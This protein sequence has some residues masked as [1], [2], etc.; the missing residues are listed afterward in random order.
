MAGMNAWQMAKKQLEIVA[1]FM[2]LE[3]W[4]YHKLSEC[5]RSLIVSVPVKMD[6]GDVM[7]FEGYRVQHNLDRGPAKGGV[8]LHPDVT[9]DEVKALAM[10][11][12][13]KCAV[14]NI[15][16]GGAKGGIACDPEKLSKGELERL[17]RRYT[18]EI[19]IIIG[20][21]KD[22]PA[23]DVNTDA[24]IMAWMMDTYSMNVGYSSPGVVTGKPISIGGSKGRNE[25][26]GKGLLIVVENLLK[27]IGKNL[28]DVEIV[29]QGFGNV[30]GNFCRL[31]YEKGAKIIAVSDVSGGIFNKKGLDINKLAK[32]VSENKS[33]KG[34][35][36]GDEISN[37]ELLE[38]SCD[39]LV[40]AALENQI[41]KE[42]A[43]KIQAKYI[44]EGA[45]GPTTPNAD[46]I[47]NERGI[48]VVPDILAN[49]G[50]VT[51]SYF[52]WVQDLQANFWTLDQINS[53]L[54]RIMT[55]AFD[56]IWNVREEKKCDMRLASYI[57]AVERVA[58]AVRLRGVYP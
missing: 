37:K 43:D 7:S 35:P 33:V 40:P 26:T 9:L 23:P 15:P 57:V 19:G 8:R 11:M 21:E 28:K 24:Q 41:T 51:V 44:V 30:G 52:E 48:V 16:Y 46:K 4:I 58:E 22:I 3:P 13:W 14:V 38:L 54:E 25:A 45:N 20:P 56:I 12:T 10:W 47:L 2:G 29:V 32:F 39:I 1:E 17:I 18:S 49:A 5:K 53:A 6:N 27:K 55:E 31:A 50:G 36:E 42:N 34:F